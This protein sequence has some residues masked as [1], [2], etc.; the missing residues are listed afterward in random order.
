MKPAMLQP[1]MATQQL[2]AFAFSAG[3]SQGTLLATDELVIW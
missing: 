3:Q 1:F 2:N